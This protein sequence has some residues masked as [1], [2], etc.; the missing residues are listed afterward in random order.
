MIVGKS[1]RDQSAYFAVYSYPLISRFRSAFR[2]RQ[3]H[4]F[5]LSK[6]SVYE[7]NVRDANDW[8]DEIRRQIIV[9]P[10][11]HVIPASINQRKLCV[12]VNPCSGPGRALQIFQEQVMP[13]FAE[14]NVVCKLVITGM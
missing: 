13:V 7:E 4:T 6:K 9:V 3:V 12:L 14:A 2:H 1:L 11:P 5:R 8:V 10:P